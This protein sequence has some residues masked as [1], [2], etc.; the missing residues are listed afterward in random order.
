MLK[1]FLKEY[2]QFCED[3]AGVNVELYVPNESWTLIEELV[4]CFEPLA[5][6]CL[7]LQ[8]HDITLTNVFTIYNVCHMEVSE[9]GKLYSTLHCRDIE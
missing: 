2:Q 7:K 8:K 6:A 1:I 4:L 9:L 3:Y 5:K